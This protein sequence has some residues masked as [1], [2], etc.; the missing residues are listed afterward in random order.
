MLVTEFI[1]I[2]EGPDLVHVSSIRFL[3]FIFNLEKPVSIAVAN[4][5]HLALLTAKHY[6]IDYLIYQ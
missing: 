5:F 4:E 3:E 2:F 6:S 1:T